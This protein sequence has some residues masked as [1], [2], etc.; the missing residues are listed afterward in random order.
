MDKENA[1]TRKKLKGISSVD[2][3]RS[4]LERTMLSEEEKK[5]LLMH[6]KDKKSLTYIADELG[7]SEVTV[8]RKLHHKYINMHHKIIP[9]RQVEIPRIIPSDWSRYTTNDV[10]DNVLPKFVKS[11]MTQYKD[12]EERTKQLY[13]EVWQE[14]I[15]YGM[16]ADAEYISDL[17]EDVT[18][19]IKKVNR[20]CEQLNGTGY[21]S[22]AIHNMQD[23]YHEKYKKKYNEEY[24]DKEVRKLK[25]QNK[26]K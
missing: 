25:E 24:T 22:V 7:M 1:E 2:E 17:V 5:I 6:Y 12:W 11:A 18:K 8:K 15:N 26:R 4:I 14:C 23:K 16:T 21:D 13:E 3:F 19:E 9:M 20:M 10:N